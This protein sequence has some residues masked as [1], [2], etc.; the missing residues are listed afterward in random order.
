MK[1]RIRIAI[2]KKGRLSAETINLL[3]SCGLKLSTSNDQLF[4]QSEEMPLD[5]LYI[6]EKEIP[7]FVNKGICDLGI[8]GKNSYYESNLSQKNKNSEILLNLGYSKCSLCIAI[9]ENSNIKK[10]TDLKNKKI[11]TYYP[12]LTQ[13]FLKTKN[14]K[15]EMVLMTGSVEIAPRLK[16]ADAISD[17]VSTGSTLSKNNLFKFKTI[18]N[19][20][21]LLLKTTKKISRE[22]NEIIERLLK[23]IKGVIKATNSK[24]IMLHVNKNRLSKVVKMLPGAERPTILPLE[25]NPRKYAVH[26]VCEENVFWDTIEKLNKEGAS[27]ILVLP[28]EKMI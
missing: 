24:Y 27:A 12:A 16:I 1:E 25:G 8:V 13:K 22:R 3:R 20:E 7:D 10:I 28:I 2:Q 19:S 6:R 17:I 23:R 26:A 4:S 11:A 14:I 9:P 5:I 18:L 21:A 15:S